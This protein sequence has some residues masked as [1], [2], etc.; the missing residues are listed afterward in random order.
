MFQRFLTVSNEED[1]VSDVLGEITKTNKNIEFLSRQLVRSVGDSV[2]QIRVKAYDYL[3][4]KRIAHDLG[5]WGIKINPDIFLVNNSLDELC[6]NEIVEDDRDDE[7]YN[8]G[9]Q[10]YGGPPYRAGDEK[11]KQMRD[12]FQNVKKDIHELLKK[13]KVKISDFLKGSNKTNAADAKN[14]AA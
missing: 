7:H 10:T 4:N 12:D 14:R 3:I 13:E 9:S 8:P 2:T 6:G 1:R 5:I 11:V